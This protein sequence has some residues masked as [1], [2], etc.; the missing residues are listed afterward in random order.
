MIEARATVLLQKTSEALLRSPVLVGIETKVSKGRGGGRT[1]R[2]KKG[3]S[4]YVNPACRE[5]RKSKL[6]I[7]LHTHTKTERD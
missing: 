5:P 1:R 6:C 2:R 3:R 4:V 7:L